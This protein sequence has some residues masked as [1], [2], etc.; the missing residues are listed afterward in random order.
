MF[1]PIAPI[2]NNTIDRDFQTAEFFNHLHT[3]VLSFVA[4][5][6]L[7]KT[8]SP[9]RQHR[10]FSSKPTYLGHHAIGI[11]AVHKIVIHRFAQ[12]LKRK[13]LFIIFKIGNRIIINIHSI[14]FDGHKIR[15]SSM[16]ILVLK[17]MLRI[18]TIEFIIQYLSQSIN[19]FVFF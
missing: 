9:Q 12:T 15:R 16:H 17:M 7:K 2:L 8:V 19:G 11:S 10:R 14:A 6:T 4:L 5:F 1:W 3:F 13:P 18:T